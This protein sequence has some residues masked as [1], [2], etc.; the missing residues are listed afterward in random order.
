[1]EHIGSTSVPGLA[2]KPIIDMLFTVAN[3]TDEAEYVPTLGSVCFELRVQEPDH[4]MLRTRAGDVH[5]HVP[6]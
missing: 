3:V 6:A 2:A 5:L 1:M 4:R